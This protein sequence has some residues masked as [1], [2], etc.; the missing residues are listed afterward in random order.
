MIRPI[1]IRKTKENV[2]KSKRFA[3]ECKKR[4]GCES[5]QQVQ[6]ENEASI[7]VTRVAREKVEGFFL[8]TTP[9]C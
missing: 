9:I 8:D 3:K 2:A 7:E 4:Y 5:P 6:Q 1:A